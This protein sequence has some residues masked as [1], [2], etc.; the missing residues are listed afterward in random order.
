MNKLFPY[1]YDRPENGSVIVGALYWIVCY[2]AIPFVT[3]VI[4]F[5]FEGELGAVAWVDIIAYG[6]NF[7]GMLTIYRSYLSDSFLNVQ[8]QKASFIKTVLISIGL[9]FLTEMAIVIHG[10][11]V[12]W[13]AVLWTYP[14]SE[15]SVLLP[16]AAVV[17]KNPV[18][19]TLCMVVLTPVTLSCMFYGTVF[20]PVACNRPWLGYVVM[21]AV[22]LLP[23]LFN[24]WWL[25]TGG[26]EWAVYALQLPV[27]MIACWAY[28]K[29]DT[30][31]APIL[32]HSGANLL[33]SLVFL[34][35]QAVGFL[36]LR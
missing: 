22:L 30:I 15:T 8:I 32:T 24:S 14:M 23:R 35:L 10:L 29:T 4:A 13:D 19:G 7:I 17:M 36:Y 12:N 9:V 31:W 1:M 25:E 5:A 11:Q 18:F 21:G 20:A 3:T 16:T 26:Y 33:M 2:I 28:Q 34:V 27:H 6:L